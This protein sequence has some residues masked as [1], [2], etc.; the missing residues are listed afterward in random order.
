M[1]N[2]LLSNGRISSLDDISQNTCRDSYM[3]TNLTRSGLAAV[4]LL[5]AFLSGMV[6]ACHE[7]DILPGIRAIGHIQEAEKIVLARMVEGR[8][9]EERRV[10]R[11]GRCCCGTDG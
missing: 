9:S 3:G 4:A 11:E 5:F 6:E 2:H 10:G 8:R 1:T 7:L